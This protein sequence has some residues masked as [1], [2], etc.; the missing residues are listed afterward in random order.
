MKKRNTRDGGLTIGL[1]LG[2]RWSEG[3]VLGKRSE[4]PVFRPV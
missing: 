3:R 4:N 1:D 2:D